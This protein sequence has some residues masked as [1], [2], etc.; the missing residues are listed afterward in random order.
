MCFKHLMYIYALKYI[1]FVNIVYLACYAVSYFILFQS[2]IP[3]VCF[4][5]VKVNKQIRQT[6]F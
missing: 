2:K 6:E 1:F 5:N 3:I 4:P